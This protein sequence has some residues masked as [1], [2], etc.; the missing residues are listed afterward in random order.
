VKEVHI[1]RHLAASL[2]VMTSGGFV[3]ALLAGCSY[4]KT[5]HWF[6]AAYVPPKKCNPMQCK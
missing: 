4:L 1:E 3:H 6:R 2:A 5:C